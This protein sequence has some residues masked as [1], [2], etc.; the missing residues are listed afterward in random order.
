MEKSKYT[1]QK[2]YYTIYDNH[3]EEI[4]A[5]GIAEECAKQLGRSLDSFYSMVYRSKKGKTKKYTIFSERL[6]DDLD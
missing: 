5:F 6:Y 4:I 1:R 2:L 3:S